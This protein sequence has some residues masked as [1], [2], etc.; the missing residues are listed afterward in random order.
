[1]RDDDGRPLTGRDIWREAVKMVLG[2]IVI[3]IGV[4]ASALLAAI[5]RGDL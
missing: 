1:M 5:I 2:F 3:A 4:G